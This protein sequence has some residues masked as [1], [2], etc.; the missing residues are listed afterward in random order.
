MNTE[1]INMKLVP[2][3]KAAL[4][5]YDLD[6]GDY[7]FYTDDE[8]QQWMICALPGGHIAHLPIRPLRSP[9]TNGGHSWDWD[10]NEQKP[11]LLPSVNSIGNWHGWIREGRMVS[12]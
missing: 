8:N 10:R 11:T 5:V 12:C 3:E 6:P 7:Y 2:R 9:A 4:S 1:S